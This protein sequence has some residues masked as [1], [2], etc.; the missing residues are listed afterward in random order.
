M[1]H[2]EIEQNVYGQE[3]VFSRMSK[4]RYHLGPD[5]LGDTHSRRTETNI[6]QYKFIRLE[7]RANYEPLIMALKG[8]QLA[9][10][11]ADYLT[12]EQLAS[13]S[14]LREQYKELKEWSDNPT[15]IAPRTRGRFIDAIE[16]GLMGESHNRPYH[17]PHY[18]D[19][20]LGAIDVQLRLFNKQIRMQNKQDQ[21]AAVR[22]LINKIKP[23]RRPGS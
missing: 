4:R 7:E 10:N 1:G 20:T 21:H 13:S 11:P 22:E 5:D 8:L 14:R 23:T 16:K 3:L 18:I 19:W 12:T 15:E 9:Y 6:Q 2:D 17:K